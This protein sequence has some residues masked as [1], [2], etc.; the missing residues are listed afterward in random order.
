MP[1]PT[2]RARSLFGLLLLAGS[3]TAS[4]FAA[5]PGERAAVA[6]PA[7]TIA[8]RTEKVRSTE[9]AF[10]KSMADRDLA[11]FSRFIAPD[12]VFLDGKDAARGAPAV[13]AAW[14]D[15]FRGATAPFSWE[16]D[17][18]EVLPTGRLALS[19]GPVHN[20]HVASQ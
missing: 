2:R 8:Q 19:S 16:P 15:L 13:I 12:A 3:C 14:R 9:L 5:M 10:A 20:A 18:I 7:A 6:L 4:A 11:A 1:T 17:Q